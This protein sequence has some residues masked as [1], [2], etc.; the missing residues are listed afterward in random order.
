MEMR[1]S[2]A[3]ES[4]HEFLLHKKYK[5]AK[6]ILRE[7][8]CYEEG[9]FEDAWKEILDEYS[10]TKMELV[11]ISKDQVK[12]GPQYVVRI[13]SVVFIASLCKFG[14]LQHHDWYKPEEVDEVLEI[15][16]YK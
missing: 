13:G 11:P 2:C 3:S 6:K 8:G 12:E 1:S 16:L 9:F 7:Y 5:K 4:L 14:F 10:A 15:H